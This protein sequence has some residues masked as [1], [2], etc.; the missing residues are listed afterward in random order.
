MTAMTGLPCTP[1]KATKLGPAVD[2]AWER[3]G[4][5]PSDLSFPIEFLGTWRANSTLVQ[6]ETPLG[7]SAVPNPQVSILP[8]TPSK[9]PQAFERAKSELNQTMEY[10]VKFIQNGRGQVVLDRRFNTVEMLK[11]Y[12]ADAKD[13]S[14]RIQWNINDPNGLRLSLPGGMSISTLVTRRSQNDNADQRRLET[15]EFL[16]MVNGGLSWRNGVHR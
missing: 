8:C 2:Q 5:G 7:D 6:V 11:L 1:A 14:Q 12:Y 16:R 4:G 15:S 13:L 9:L 3:L 10:L